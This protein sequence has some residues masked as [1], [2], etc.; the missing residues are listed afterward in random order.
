MEKRTVEI[1]ITDFEKI[2]KSHIQRNWI[3]S[4]V[5][6]FIISLILLTYSICLRTFGYKIQSFSYT[7]VSEINSLDIEE[8]L[9]PGKIDLSFPYWHIL[10]TCVK[11]KDSTFCVDIYSELKTPEYNILIGSGSFLIKDYKLLVKGFSKS[12]WRV[13]L[14][15]YLFCCF[16]CVLVAGS[17]VIVKTLAERKSRHFIFLMILFL[18]TALIALVI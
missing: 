14:E 2:V 3:I 13:I 4:C 16:L 8:V 1:E 18:T 10:E 17:A 15:I 12:V 11:V 7:N 5:V 6:L 9:I